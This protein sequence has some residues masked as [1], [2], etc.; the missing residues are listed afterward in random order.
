MSSEWD[1]TFSNLDPDNLD[2]TAITKELTELDAEEIELLAELES[3]QGSR[4]EL[5]E[6]IYSLS[7]LSTELN[8]IN[9]DV[10]RLEQDITRSHLMLDQVCQKVKLLDFAKSRV[11]AC[12]K[13]VD[14]VIDL[15]SCSEVV[16]NSL[17][18]GD[19]ER[20]AA[21]LHRYLVLDERMI[22]DTVSGFSDVSTVDASFQSI[23]Q[24]EV[25][26]KTLM[27][28]KFEQALVDRN[29]KAVERYFKI[30]PFLFLHE[31]GL[32]KYS[33]FLRGRISFIT[34]GRFSDAVSQSAVNKPGIGLAIPIISLFTDIQQV[35]QDKKS[36][37]D[38]LYGTGYITYIIL[39]L[40]RECDIQVRKILLQQKQIRKID[41][42]LTIINES[43]TLTGVTGNQKKLDT[44][45]LDVILT[46]LTTII[47]HAEIYFAFIHTLISTSLSEL[48]TQQTLTEDFIKESKML[49]SESKQ[50]IQELLSHYLMFENY[51]MRQSIYRA[52]E[53]NQTSGSNSLLDDT[54]YIL[55]KCL[56]RA[57]FTS[58]P[59]CI[60][61][62]LNDAGSVLLEVKSRLQNENKASSG[63]DIAGVLQAKLPGASKSADHTTLLT[64][65][66]Y[67][68]QVE[69]CLEYID[70]LACEL[71]IDLEKFFLSSEE[72]NCV[73]IR[74]CLDEFRSHSK[75]FKVMLN[76]KISEIY[77]Q[78]LLPKVHAHL[79]NYSTRNFNISTDEFS[80]HDSSAEVQGL[81]LSL[82]EQL[83]RFD[84][85]MKK[86]NF[87]LIIDHL[88]EDICQQLERVI[89]KSQFSQMGAL[90]LDKEFR[91]ISSYLSSKTSVSIR[92]KLSRT[93]QIISLLSL[94]S[95]REIRDYWKPNTGLVSSRLSLAEVKSFL[96]LRVD[97]DR[98]LIMKIR[99]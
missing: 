70:K 72:L 60:G 12:M 91:A 93:N 32:Q 76:S 25:E 78:F 17:A 46:E 54:F 26:L 59:D 96:K 64:Q 8:P 73:R 47:S 65:S 15:R 87:E 86:R 10:T 13:R 43:K 37:V 67:I 3:C 53:L 35:L 14:D 95:L 5:E 83:G 48:E 16:N 98:D 29:E 81:L 27:Q 52:S 2:I 75:V 69:T 49:V 31:E 34:E 21:H 41:Q 38:V 84:A 55:H 36:S 9:Q 94:E 28:E 11:F 22:K 20:A 45:E 77:K 66:K 79:D 99:L 23:R 82:Q 24:A 97:L 40:Q 44:K 80:H 57:I 19:Y 68:N 51:F 50:Q 42:K 1:Y 85:D 4:E 90:L 18:S 92:E 74:T 7:S 58:S 39:E 62:M 6:A 71:E 89:L 30:F 33:Q 61:A 63:V 56:R 88:L